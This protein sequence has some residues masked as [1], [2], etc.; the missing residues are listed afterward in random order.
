MRRMSRAS[1]ETE[2]KLP[3]PSTGQAF[4]ALAPLGARVVAP[5]SFEDNAVF[6]TEDGRLE[7][8]GCL[9]RL[10]SCA[11]VATVTFKAPVEGVHRHKVRVEHETVVGDPGATRRILEALG[12]RPVYRYQKFRTVLEVDGLTV[13]VDETPIGCWIELEGAPGS[14]DAV[15]ARLGFGP[16]RYVRET[17]RDLHEHACAHAGVPRGDL[18]FD[19]GRGTEGP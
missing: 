5:R 7:G 2:I 16:D 12:F 14:I 18:V 13:C 10:R 8:S 4:E 11:G 3:Y 17:Y 9:L 15:A 1:R 19:E 6:D